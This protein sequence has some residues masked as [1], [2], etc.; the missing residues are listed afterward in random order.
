ML[1]LKYFFQKNKM[2]IM[3]VSI[4]LICSIAIAFGVYAQITGKTIINK[5]NENAQNNYEEL[6]NNFQEI[7]TNTINK[8][9]TAKMNINYE[10]MLYCKYDVKEEKSGEYSINAKIPNFKGE[11]ETI[12]KIN[13]EIFDTFARKVVEIAKNSSEYTTYNL[14]YVGY[15]NNNIISLVI[16]CKYKDGINPQRKIIQT[17]N[18][19]VEDDKLLNINDIIAYKNLNKDDMQK[20]IKEEIKQI[21]EEKEL[22]NS[23]LEN[24]SEQKLNMYKRDKDSQIY[25]IDNT[26]NFF[27]GKNNYLYLVYAYGNN[28]HTS[29]IDLVIF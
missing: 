18:Y 17:Y 22:V 7:F 5:E 28:N 2:I 16:M 13:T 10:E 1:E 4:L 26:P 15:A 21:Q 6:K 25:Q 8:E 27:L 19:N 20:K 29:E 9:A 12:K 11:T 3:T 23:Q 14:D 24:I